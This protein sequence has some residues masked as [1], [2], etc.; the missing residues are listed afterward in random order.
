M[1]LF[2]ILKNFDQNT[3]I[4]RD[5]IYNT[6]FYCVVNKKIYHFS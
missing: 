4:P 1:Y 3:K 5:I 2:I 6:H